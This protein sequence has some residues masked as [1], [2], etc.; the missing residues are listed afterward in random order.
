MGDGWSFTYSDRLTVNNTDNSV[1]WFTDEGIQLNFPLN[2]YGNGTS[3]YY[4]TPKTVFGTLVYNGS[5]LGYTWTDKTG[6][7]TTFDDS[8]RLVSIFDRY[9]D[10]VKVSYVDGTTQIDKVQRMLSNAIASS[11][12]YLKFTYT[13]S[14]I[15]AITYFSSSSDTSG[16]TW[17]YGYDSS[18]YNDSSWRLV[19]VSGPVTGS[20]Q[21]ALTQYAYWPDTALHDL[22]KSV[23]DADGNVTQFTYYANRRGFQVTDAE[24]NTH[25]LYYDL[26]RSRTF[27]TDGRG[28]VT[29]YTYD[30][31][32]NITQQL[33][34]DGTTEV[35]QWYTSDLKQSDSDAYGQIESYQYDS[36]G[37]LTRL[38]D[39]LGNVTEYT[40]TDY[41]N[42][43]T[44]KRDSDG[45][46]T[47][48]FYYTASG[49]QNT[50]QDQHGA[51]FCL[52]KVVDAAG[53]VTSYTYPATNRGLPL[54]MM[55][56]KGNASMPQSA[57]LPTDIPPPTATTTPGR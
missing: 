9:G 57:A 40:Y 16:R 39:R 14:H 8:G 18:L 7:T 4:T 49:L 2:Y 29:Y 12:C 44:A 54:T 32:G 38:T 22:L 6:S 33:N 17:L 28:Q 20:D 36:N 56:P 25:S 24:G 19:S 31:D 27:Y 48:Y 13:G 46:L 21:L 53:N 10:G 52:W 41:S 5:G 34:P 45:A 3:R 43:L 47:Q 42:L 1:T 35:Y 30:G 37:N 51:D 23:T 11:E 50:S 55:S 15:S 26:N